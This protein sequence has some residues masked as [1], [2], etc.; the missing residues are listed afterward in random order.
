MIH[1]VAC[2]DAEKKEIGHH[3][4]LAYTLSFTEKWNVEIEEFDY[5]FGTMAKMFCP[6][7]RSEENANLSRGRKELLLNHWKLGINM[8]RVKDLM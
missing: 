4:R 6:C 7:V 5:E 3:F 2:S 1:N 8:Q